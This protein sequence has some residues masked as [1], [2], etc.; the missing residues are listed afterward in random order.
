MVVMFPP[1]ANARKSQ[2]PNRYSAEWAYF[3]AAQCSFKS[4]FLPAA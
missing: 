4:F 2:I 3:F 1:N